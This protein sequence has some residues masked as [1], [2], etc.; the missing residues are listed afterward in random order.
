MIYMILGSYY[1]FNIV[2]SEPCLHPRAMQGCNTSKSIVILCTKCSEQSPWMA[3]T[4]GWWTQ[5]EMHANSYWV[6]YRPSC[7]SKCTFQA[8]NACYFS[9]SP[10]LP[11]SLYG[12]PTV[13]INQTLP[14]L[15]P[16]T[17]CPLVH[18]FFFFYNLIL[19][20]NIWQCFLQN[21]TGMDANNI[22]STLVQV[23]AWCR[24]APS[25]YLSHCWPISLSS[26]LQGNELTVGPLG[27]NLFRYTLS[28]SH[29]ESWQHTCSW[30]DL[31]WKY[32]LDNS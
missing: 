11:L 24:Q 16:L 4:G 25:H 6:P 28:W 30:W 27:L 14:F 5:G 2:D 1:F 29:T 18:I 22:M 9:I 23:M 20:N 10:W 17:H 26:L 32:L 7:L 12:L 19:N 15:S 13:H 31:V 21:C 3:R 8:C